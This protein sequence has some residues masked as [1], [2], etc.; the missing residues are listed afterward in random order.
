MTSA[1]RDLAKHT[2]GP[3]AHWPLLVGLLEGEEFDGSLERQVEDA[4]TC[5]NA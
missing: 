3:G 5:A 1:E 2:E 4:V